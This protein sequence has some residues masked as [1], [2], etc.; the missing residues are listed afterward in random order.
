MPVEDIFSQRRKRLRGEVSDV[1]Q[2]ENIPEALRVQIVYIMKDAF[3]IIKHDSRAN[4]V[5][6]QG[7]CLVASD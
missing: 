1:Y 7:K 2:Y 4:K 5:Y 3:E 6:E